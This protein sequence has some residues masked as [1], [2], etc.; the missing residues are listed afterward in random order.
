[1]C[2][3][4]FQD[5]FDYIQGTKGRRI[6]FYCTADDMNA[7]DSNNYYAITFV[8]QETMQIDTFG[9]RTV[10]AVLGQEH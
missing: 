7:F 6:G 9:Y 10:T 4:E 8:S 5:I 1:M 2:H 3:Q